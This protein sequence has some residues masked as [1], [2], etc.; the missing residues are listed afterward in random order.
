MLACESVAQSLFFY[1]ARWAE[2]VT[3]HILTLVSTLLVRD[4]SG[5]YTLPI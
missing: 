1:V 2:V 4:L 5:Q 3:G